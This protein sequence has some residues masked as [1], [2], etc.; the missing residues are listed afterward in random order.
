MSQALPNPAI[1]AFK[2]KLTASTDLTEAMLLGREQ[3]KKSLEGKAQL[4]T[5]WRRTFSYVCA[6]VCVYSLFHV[7][8]TAKLLPPASVEGVD[9]GRLATAFT[10][11]LYEEEVVLLVRHVGS[12]LTL[13]LLSIKPHLPGQWSAQSKGRVQTLAS[14]LGLLEMLVTIMIN[15]EPAVVQSKA[16]KRLRYYPFSTILA[17]LGYLQ[18]AYMNMDLRRSQNQ[19][20][21][22]DM[23]MRSMAK[24]KKS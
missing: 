9:Q 7:I 12:S 10:I 17:I 20:K 1:D 13:F 21:E 24:T 14:I 6:V 3:L 4:Y 8:E 5:N 19:F 23:S 18:N 22:L 11:G 16:L 15:N 2:S